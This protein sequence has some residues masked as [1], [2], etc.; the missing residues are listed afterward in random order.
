[1]K[2][3]LPVSLYKLFLKL[4]EVSDGLLWIMNENMYVS[5]CALPYAMYLHSS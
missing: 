1:M 5:T 2:A 3:V 4:L